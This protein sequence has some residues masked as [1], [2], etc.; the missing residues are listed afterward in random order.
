MR[1]LFLL[2]L[3]SSGQA[4]PKPSQHNAE[5]C[6][7]NDLP[8]CRFSLRYSA[9]LSRWTVLRQLNRCQTSSQSS[10][11]NPAFQCWRTLC[12][13]LPPGRIPSLLS[14]SPSSARARNLLLSCHV[15]MPTGAAPLTQFVCRCVT[16]RFREI[17]RTRRTCVG[18]PFVSSSCKFYLVHRLTWFSFSS[19][20]FL[21]F[22]QQSLQIFLKIM[23][24][25]LV[26]TKCFFLKWGTSTQLKGW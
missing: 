9:L 25:A 22:L 6:P 17:P 7:T 23:V 5:V 21:S 16:A 1:D 19:A 3:S 15:V 2:H 18:F 26:S 8:S 12:T 24:I 13:P 11:L 14:W 4:D 20:S 10:T